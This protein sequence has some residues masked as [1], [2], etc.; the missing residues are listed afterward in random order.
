MEFSKMSRHFVK[1][2]RR[3]KEKMTC[4]IYQTM[5][6]PSFCA[7]EDDDGG[8]GGGDGLN[9]DSRWWGRVSK[10]QSQECTQH[11]PFNLR[12]GRWGKDV[13]TGIL[14]VETLISSR[15]S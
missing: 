11:S 13:E 14:G 5:Y 1:I 15:H 3:K 9:G 12:A 7:T 2:Y 4:S 10:E 8:G 6:C